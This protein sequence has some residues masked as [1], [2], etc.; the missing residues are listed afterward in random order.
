MQFRIFWLTSLY[1]VYI[2]FIFG[3]V[4]FLFSVF[5]GFTCFGGGR[6]I[7]IGSSFLFALKRDTSFFNVAPCTKQM[8]M[9]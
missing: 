6:K 9:E 7:I 3:Y 1:N 2:N 8:F 5:F 4:F